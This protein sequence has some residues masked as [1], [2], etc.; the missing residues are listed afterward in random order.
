L[1]VA[2]AV[3]QSKVLVAT[4][5]ILMDT[6][7]LAQAVAAKVA[8]NLLVALADV[9]TMVVVLPLIQAPWALVAIHSLGI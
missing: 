9:V 3:A 2:V 1:L 7:G 6:M 8:H 4:E 5:V